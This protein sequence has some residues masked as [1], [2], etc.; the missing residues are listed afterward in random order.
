MRQKIAIIGALTNFGRA[1]ADYLAYTHW[2]IECLYALDYTNNQDI[3]IPYRSSF[4]PVVP[5][6]AFDFHQVHLSYLCLPTLLN[7]DKN[8]ILQ[9]GSYLIDCAGI[10]ENAPCMIASLSHSKSINRQIIANPTA[11]TIALGHV[12]SPIHHQLKINS[13]ESTMLLSAN[14]FGITAIQDLVAQSRCLFTREEPKMNF[15]HKIQAFN[16]IPD[17]SG[18]LNRRTA[19]EIK[20]L[21]HIPIGICSCLAPVFQGECYSLTFTVEKQCTLSQ[22]QKICLDNPHCTWNQSLTPDLNPTTQDI[23]FSNSIHIANL[24]PVAFRPR[25][26]HTWILCDSLRVGSVP[27]AIQ[28]GKHLLN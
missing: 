7:E 18:I 15:I 14:L 4:L 10:I 5:L 2:P 12:L 21:L 16:L 17:I 28:I 26:F 9:S 20:S 24:A 25:T 27:N 6:N 11:P 8:I 3:Q 19:R 13:A 22:I 1:L 23:V